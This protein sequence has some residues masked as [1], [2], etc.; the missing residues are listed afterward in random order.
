VIV[1]LTVIA[2]VF[3]TVIMLLE[4]ISRKINLISDK[5]R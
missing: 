3:V 5:K 1:T 4:L 2:R